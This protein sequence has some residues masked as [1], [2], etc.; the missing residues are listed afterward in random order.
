LEWKWREVALLKGVGDGVI[1]DCSGPSA[2]VKRD[3]SVQA[4][5]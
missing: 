5:E 2:V 3:P 4:R 1:G